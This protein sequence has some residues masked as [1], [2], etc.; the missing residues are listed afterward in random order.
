VLLLFSNKSNQKPSLDGC[1]ILR[2]LLSKT[3]LLW[4][5]QERSHRAPFLLKQSSHSKAPLLHNSFIRISQSPDLAASD[6]VG[7]VIICFADAAKV[8]LS[9]TEI[10]YSRFAESS[11]KSSLKQAKKKW[12]KTDQRESFW[13]GKTGIFYYRVA[14]VASKF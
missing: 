6:E 14:S 13:R 11:Q 12:R 4:N 10:K 5:S 1:S 8:R 9:N 7:V 2:K 3:G